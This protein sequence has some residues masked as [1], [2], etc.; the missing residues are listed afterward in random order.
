MAV[1]ITVDGIMVHITVSVISAMTIIRPIVKTIPVR[2]VTKDWRTGWHHIQEYA[3]LWCAIGKGRV[4]GGHGD[5]NYILLILAR[6]GRPG[7]GARNFEIPRV[8]HEQAHLHARRGSGC[9]WLIAWRPTGADVEYW[10]T[11]A[12]LVHDIDGPTVALLEQVLVDFG[13]PVLKEPR[14]LL[15]ASEHDVGDSCAPCLVCAGVARIGIVLARQMLEQ[16]RDRCAATVFV[17]V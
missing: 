1:S 3:L 15:L 16:D 8:L 12:A 4:P 7:Q 11:A 10:R 17:E 6:A 5:T 9:N 2:V 14:N 13:E